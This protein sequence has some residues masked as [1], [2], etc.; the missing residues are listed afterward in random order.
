MIIST[1]S[2]IDL[3]IKFWH[4]NPVLFHQKD[5]ISGTFKAGYLELPA[6]IQLSDIR[7]DMSHHFQE[8][9]NRLYLSFSLLRLGLA[10][11]KGTTFFSIVMWE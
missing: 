8:S 3:D 1:Q 5:S 6:Y 11:R 7:D 9:L 10:G 2:E 4:L